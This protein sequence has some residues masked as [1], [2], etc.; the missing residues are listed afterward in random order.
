[1]DLHLHTPMLCGNNAT[2]QKKLC[3]LHLLVLTQ[4]IFSHYFLE[5][6]DHKW[7]WQSIG[8][9]GCDVSEEGQ[10]ETEDKPIYCKRPL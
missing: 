3:F 9:G 1:M 4:K 8:M 7:R 6:C 10:K 2:I 5:N